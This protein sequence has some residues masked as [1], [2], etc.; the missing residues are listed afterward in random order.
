MR[1]HFE[2]VLARIH[3][4]CND[5]E[6]FQRGMTTKIV[7]KRST[8]LAGQSSSKQWFGRRHRSRSHS[9]ASAPSSTGP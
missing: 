8:N 9:I 5:E 4:L 6:H 7:K 3:K 1:K 2:H